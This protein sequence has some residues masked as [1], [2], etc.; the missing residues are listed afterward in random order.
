MEKLHDRM[1]VTE[2]LVKMKNALAKLLLLQ[3]ENFVTWE[4][5]DDK[6]KYDCRS[7][8]CSYT[9]CPVL[10]GVGVLRPVLRQDK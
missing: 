10:N 4:E 3:R 8:Q 6:K 2:N 7:G 5:G 1:N 9:L